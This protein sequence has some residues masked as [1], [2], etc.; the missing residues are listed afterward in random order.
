MVMIYTFVSHHQVI[1]SES[2]VAEAILKVTRGHQV[3]K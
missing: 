2:A 1:T 3:I